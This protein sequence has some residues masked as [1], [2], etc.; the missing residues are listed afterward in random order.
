MALLDELQT[1][2]SSINPG[3]REGRIAKAIENQTAKLPSDTFLWTAVGCMAASLT[4]QLAKK[5]H[6]SLFVGQWVAPLLLFG[7]YNK[8]VKVQGHDREDRDNEISNF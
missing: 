6:F 8:I 1:K 4:L 2:A 3:K 7:I 5:D